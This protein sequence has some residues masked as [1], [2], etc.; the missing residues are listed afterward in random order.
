MKKSLKQMLILTVMLL[1]ML[2][3]FTVAT[4][5]ATYADDNAAISGGAV[6]R[7]GAAGSG[8][9]YDSVG[10]AVEAVPFNGTESTVITLITNATWNSATAI[11]EKALTIQGANNNIALSLA[12]GCALYNN[13][14]LTLDNLKVSVDGT[15]NA[16][17]TV[18]LE[19]SAINIRFSNCTITS[20]IA[21]ESNFVRVLNYDVSADTLEFSNVTF[22]GAKFDLIAIGA[23]GTTVLGSAA[24]PVL[25]DN[26]VGEFGYMLYNVNGV[27][28]TVHLKVVNSDVS[29]N[30]HSFV[31][32]TVC[33]DAAAKDIFSYGYR[34]GDV[35]LGALD[36]VYFS[37]K[38]EAL[39][40][41]VSGVKVYDISGA[42]PVEVIK[43]CEHTYIDEVV[44]PT[45]TEDGYTKHTCSKCGTTFE[46]TIVPNLGGHKTSEATCVKKAVCSV[47]KAE[48]GDLARHK[49]GLATCT[50]KA[51]CSV[52][53]AE[54]GELAKHV[55]T[56]KNDKC[57]KCGTEISADELKI[58]DSASEKKKGCKGTVGV[59]GLA[60]VAALGSCA[61]FVEKKRK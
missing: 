32:T 15:H 25:F 41:A 5:A 17:N 61:L 43:T 16:N 7:I 51:K 4:S 30:V 18:Y 33:D 1:C 3:I 45:C 60:L 34:V 40:A 37:I 49:Y 35:A 26:V 36:N 20:N 27:N 22:A 19:G 9:Y 48:I 13:S 28:A 55:D 44:A 12:N 10:A 31:G 8:T 29:G 6:A 21:A 14:S 59:A 11:E 46:D 38:S 50:E 24:K 53:G 42:T 54:R 23:G 47:C 56:D 2:A 39:Q 52:C 57:D 58:D